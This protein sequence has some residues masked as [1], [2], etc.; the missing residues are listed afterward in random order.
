TLGSADK[1]I[2]LSDR[3]RRTAEEPLDRDD[4]GRALAMAVTG[5]AELAEALLERESSETS[6]GQQVAETPAPRSTGRRAGAA[7]RNV[8][9]RALDGGVPGRSRSPASHARPTCSSILAASDSPWCTAL[10]ILRPTRGTEALM[11]AAM[12]TTVL[13]SAVASVIVPLQVTGAPTMSS[14]MV[15]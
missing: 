11:A 3:L 1:V 6:P 13:P 14:L 2:D 8:S 9:L 5:P 7:E 12:R 15:P 10:S 4:L